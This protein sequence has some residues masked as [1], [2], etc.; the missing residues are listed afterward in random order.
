MIHA[1]MSTTCCIVQNENIETNLFYYG[2]SEE[3]RMNSFG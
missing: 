2:Y 3:E 1:T